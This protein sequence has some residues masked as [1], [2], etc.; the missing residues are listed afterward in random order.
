MDPVSGSSKQITPRFEIDSITAMPKNA[1]Y[2]QTMSVLDGCSVLA[3]YLQS[4]QLALLVTIHTDLINVTYQFGQPIRDL[5]VD[6]LDIGVISLRRRA[7]SRH[8]CEV[9]KCGR[10]M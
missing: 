6:R 9:V 7:N 3:C 8:T 1:M 4:K 10:Q 5:R 2:H